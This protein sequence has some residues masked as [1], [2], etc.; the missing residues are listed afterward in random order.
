[1]AISV[2]MSL[3]CGVRYQMRSLNLGINSHGKK[4]KTLLTSKGR[5]R[6]KIN[7]NLGIKLTGLVIIQTNQEKLTRK[8]SSLLK[9]I[10]QPHKKLNRLSLRNLNIG[11]EL[12]P[13]TS[14][15]TIKTIC[16]LI[17]GTTMHGLSLL[18]KK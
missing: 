1:M 15:I 4:G 13:Q 11:L 2:I 14:A 8:T 10:I 9:R 17:F 3:H 5:P 18:I 16:Q 6:A 12:M 7:K